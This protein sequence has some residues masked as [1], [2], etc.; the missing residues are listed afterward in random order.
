LFEILRQSVVKVQQCQSNSKQTTQ[1]IFRQKSIWPWKLS[2]VHS[3]CSNFL[4][5]SWAFIRKSTSREPLLSKNEETK[6][7]KSSLLPANDSD[8]KCLLALSLSRQ[9]LL[10]SGKHSKFWCNA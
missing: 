8:W 1:V 6:T 10:L 4:P 5:Q 9:R 7:V 3:P 2:Q